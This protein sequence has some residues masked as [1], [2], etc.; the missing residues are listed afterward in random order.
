VTIRAPKR[1]VILALIDIWHCEESPFAQVM[2]R[3]VR[4][5]SATRPNFNVRGSERNKL[6]I[7]PGTLMT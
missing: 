2:N 4:S 5:N 3:I 6:E 1:S 7:D